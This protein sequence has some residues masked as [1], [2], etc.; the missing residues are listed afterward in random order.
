MKKI[1]L[2]IAITLSLALGFNASSINASTTTASATTETTNYIYVN[3]VIDG[4]IW[5]F[6]YTEDGTFVAQYLAQ[7]Q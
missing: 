7:Q 1:I 6:V 3:V 2:T 4:A 5:V